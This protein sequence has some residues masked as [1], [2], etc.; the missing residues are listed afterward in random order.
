MSELS[1]IK[2]HNKIYCEAIS[3]S[4]IKAEHDKTYNNI[5][6]ADKNGNVF[7]LSTPLNQV[8]DISTRDYFQHVKQ[9]QNFVI[10]GYSVGKVSG[11]KQVVTAYPLFNSKGEFNGMVGAAIDVKWLDT[12]ATQVKLPPGY[13][14]T[15]IDH[16]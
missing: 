8:L 13:S 15:A 5:G 14:I 16:H 4:I 7:C 6:A 2:S 1:E 11:N 9:A 3:N 12:I 10:G